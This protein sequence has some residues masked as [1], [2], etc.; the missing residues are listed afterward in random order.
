MNSTP[1]FALKIPKIVIIGGGE[2]G[3]VYLRQLL[4][5]AARGRLETTGILVVDRDPDCLVSRES[6]PKVHLEVADWSDW[7]DLR[8]GRLD[9]EDHLVPYHWAPHL[10]LGWLER[11][12]A[13]KGV[14]ARRGGA[15]P[16]RGLPF[17]AATSGGDRALSYAAWVCPALCIEPALCPKTQGARDWSLARDLEEGGA[18]V[19]F[20][21]LHLLY[22]VG[23][24]KIAEIHAARDL[25]LAGLEGGSREYLI[26]TSSHCHALATTLSVEPAGLN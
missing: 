12:L 19:V 20:R 16:P 5:A 7:L 10:L 4:R 24:I 14:R 1:S 22:G 3:S 18:A 8:L 17:E 25:I 2:V 23:T 26:A 15:I 21:C 6:D 9:P 11:E 13:S